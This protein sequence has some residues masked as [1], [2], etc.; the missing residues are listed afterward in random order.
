MFRLCLAA[1]IALAAVAAP[2]ESKDTLP[3]I[4]SAWNYNDPVQSEANFRDLLAS[5]QRVENAAY[6]AE[7]RTQLARSLGLQGRFD[8]AN[9]ILDDIH[10]KLAPDMKVAAI[11][12]QLEKGRV[13]N[14]S[15]HPA[16]SIGFFKKALALAQAVHAE[17]LAIDAAHMLGIVSPADAAIAWNRRAIRMAESATDP[18]ARNW[19]GP[20]YNNLGWTYVDKHEYEKALA[21]FTKDV[22]FRKSSGRPFEAGIALWSRAKTLRLM[23][24][25]KEALAIQIRLANDPLR[26]GKPADGYTHEEIGECLLSLGK[27]DEA[28]PHFAIAYRRLGTDAWLRD[29]EPERLAR[30]RRLAQPQDDR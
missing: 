4:D 23:G 1:A 3:T 17:N 27:P 12:W 28:A 30:L 11:R 25:V 24:R 20:L 21:L 7:V 19:L 2:A 9:T 5:A 22:A 8:E 10:K 18:R 16:D 29:H 13:V 15:G 26:N 14:S 6:A